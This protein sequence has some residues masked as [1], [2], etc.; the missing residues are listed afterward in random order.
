VAAAV[1]T[2]VPIPVA[3]PP[4]RVALKDVPRMLAPI[5]IGFNANRP[6]N[7]NARSCCTCK[8]V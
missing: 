5:P 1:V 3:A 2:T 7:K 8:K 6:T 4:E